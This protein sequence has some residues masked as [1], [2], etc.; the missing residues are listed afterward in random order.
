L[1]GTVLAEDAVL[2]APACAHGTSRFNLDAFFWGGGQG[3]APP[4]EAAAPGMDITGASTP[5]LELLYKVVAVSDDGT[6][7]FPEF[8]EALMEWKWVFR[9]PPFHV[10]RAVHELFADPAARVGTTPVAEVATSTKMVTPSGECVTGALCLVRV[11]SAEEVQAGVAGERAVKT[12]NGGVAHLRD[13]RL[14]G[15]LEMPC[16]PT[17]HG[18]RTAFTFTLDVARGP[19]I[20]SANGDREW[21]EDGQRHRGGGGPAVELA[22]GTREWWHRGQRHRD[23]GFPAVELADGTRE[24]WEGGQRHRDGGLP[25]VELADGTK[26]WWEGGQRHREPDSQPAL[27]RERHKEWYTHGILT[28]KEIVDDWAT[29]HKEWYTHGIL[30]RKEIV[31]GWGTTTTYYNARGQLH[32][33]GDLPALVLEGYYK[34][35]QEWWRDGVLHRDAGDQPAV[36]THTGTMKWFG[37]CTHR[38]KTMEWWMEGKRARHPGLPTVELPSGRGL[39]A[40]GSSRDPISEMGFSGL[41]RQ[42]S[43]DLELLKEGRLHCDNDADGEWGPAAIRADG[44]REWW[45]KGVRH[46]SDGKPAVKHPH[47]DKE[48]WEHG[49]RHRDNGLPAVEL[50]D[51]SR[52]WFVR[53]KATRQADVRLHLPCIVRADGH[54][55]WHDE[56]GKRH[57]EG[58]LPAVE[59]P[60]GTL[61]WWTHGRRDRTGDQPAIIRPNGDQEWWVDGVLHRDDDRPAIVCTRGIKLWFQR[62]VKQRSERA[63]CAIRAD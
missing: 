15:L 27:V 26:E 40:F 34:G 19:A 5:P 4:R 61:E 59:L 25:A 54:Q 6:V 62:G 51:G 58:G 30:T 22:D 3:E 24:W 56:A 42:P 49:V 2:P 21:Y 9:N 7:R 17:P 35:N 55:E 1:S 57:R 23:G 41:V 47:G 14:H 48:W 16:V 13:G 46:R 29:R 43:G 31:D 8:E 37:T 32:R 44:T 60:D 38:D 45:R 39:W 50:A 11:L 52:Q 28:R 63:P 20:V 10:A 53:G 33:E 12:K 18:A 36:I